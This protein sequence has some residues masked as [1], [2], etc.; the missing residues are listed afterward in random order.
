V[1][2]ARHQRQITGVAQQ[3]GQRYD[4]VVQVALIAGRPVETR[5][6]DLEHGADAGDVVIGSG[7]QHRAG[8][9]AGRRRM[10]VGEPDA[11][12]GQPVQVGRVDLATECADI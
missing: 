1:P 6:R 7:E 5:A 8:R 3:F 4:P 9:R 10:K 2:F 11:R 12:V